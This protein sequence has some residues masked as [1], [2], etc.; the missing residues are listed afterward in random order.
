[1]LNEEQKNAVI[2]G[3]GPL[4]IVAGAG[5]GKTAFFCSSFSILFSHILV[6]HI[7]PRIF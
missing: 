7:D 2:H 4:L 5:T 6:W 1:M 3:Q